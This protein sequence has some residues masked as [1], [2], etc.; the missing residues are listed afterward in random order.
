MR[1]H[2][3]GPDLR[4]AHVRMQNRTAEAFLRALKA[5]HVSTGNAQE[6]G[7]IL[8]EAFNWA[9]L[10]R[11]AAPHFKRAPGLCCMLGPMSAAPKARPLA[12]FGTLLG[13]RCCACPGPTM[14]HLAGTL[15]SRLGA[16]L[17]AHACM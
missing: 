14:R 5:A 1:L 9:A 13:M 4:D 7:E 8:P 10:G 12:C 3:L 2:F 15:L 6:H 11:A 16:R 17:R